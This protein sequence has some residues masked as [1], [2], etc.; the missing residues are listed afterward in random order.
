MQKIQLEIIA[1][2]SRISGVNPADLSILMV[3]IKQGDKSNK[4][5]FRISKYQKED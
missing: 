4:K 1:K 2:T 3:F 5:R